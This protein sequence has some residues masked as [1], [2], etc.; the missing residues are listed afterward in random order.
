MTYELDYTSPN[1]DESGEEI[2]NAVIIGWNV[3]EEEDE[4]I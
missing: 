2:P 4:K 3:E 1:L